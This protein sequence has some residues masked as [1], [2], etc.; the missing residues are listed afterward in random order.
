[1]SQDIQNYQIPSPSIYSWI[2]EYMAMR[3]TKR[4]A[5]Y[6]QRPMLTWHGGWSPAQPG[7][8][9]PHLPLPLP[10]SF[11]TLHPVCTAP[12]QAITSHSGRADLPSISRSISSRSLLSLG[13]VASIAVNLTSAISL[14]I[15]ESS[16][17]QR[18][19]GHMAA[20]C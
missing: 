16:P 9:V 12:S 20:G 1:M 3:G 6:H 8:S 10:V 5:C 2:L 7:G 4:W 15:L 17:R 11:R 14:R 13:I 19:S 18:G